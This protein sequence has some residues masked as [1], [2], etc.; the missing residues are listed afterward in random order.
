MNE[1]R[2]QYLVWIVIVV[3]G[4]FGIGLI[5]FLVGRLSA[6]ALPSTGVTA[7]TDTP[8]PLPPP[9]ITI[10]GIKAKAEL[11]TIEYNTVAEIYNENMPQG[12]L[13]QTLGTKER[14]LMLVYGDVRA[15][16]D[17]N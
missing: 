12:W 16:F 14:L 17:L 8:T 15:G 13:D 1:F 3:L 7:P 10:Q 9:I 4:L 11:A 6:R 5:A 2:R